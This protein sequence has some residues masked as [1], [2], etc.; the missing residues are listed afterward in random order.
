MPGYKERKCGEN[1]SREVM[2]LSSSATSTERE[3]G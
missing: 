1:P 2:E 3:K